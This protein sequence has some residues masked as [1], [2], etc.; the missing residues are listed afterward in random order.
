MRR[1][2]LL[3]HVTERKK[4]K[5]KKER[6]KERGKDRFDGTTPGIV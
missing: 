3:K 5:R 4:E 2:C 1:N 6:K